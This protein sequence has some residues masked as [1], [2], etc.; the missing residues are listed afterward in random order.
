M[1]GRTPPTRM[2]VRS[3]NF[4]IRMRTWLYRVPLRVTTASTFWFGWTQSIHAEWHSAADRKSDRPGPTS[5]DSWQWR[6]D[7]DY[8]VIAC[9][10]GRG[11]KVRRGDMRR[12]LQATDGKVFTLMSMHLLIEETRIREYRVRR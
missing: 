11:F 3:M 2:Q 10:A 1:S 5:N 8:D 9:I 4:R 7:K 6:T 12:L